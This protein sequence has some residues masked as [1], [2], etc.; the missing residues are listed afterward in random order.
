MLFRLPLMGFAF[1]RGLAA[2]AT[3]TLVVLAVVALGALAIWHYAV[4]SPP[5]IEIES[6]VVSATNRNGDKD[7]GIERFELT[8]LSTSQV[9]LHGAASQNSSIMRIELRWGQYQVERFVG[10]GLPR[11]SAAREFGGLLPG[12]RYRLV[13]WGNDG[14]GEAAP[15]SREFVQ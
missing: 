11:V 3:A 7:L 6:G 14:S 8:D 15:T 4:L 9:V 13:V 12:H 10:G 1:G 2:I 5:K